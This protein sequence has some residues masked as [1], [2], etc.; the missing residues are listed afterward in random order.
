MKTATNQVEE[1]DLAYIHDHADAELNKISGESILITGGAGFLGYYFTKSILNWND[2]HLSKPIQISILDNL[3][4]GIPS[5]L[6]EITRRSDVTLIKQNLI[7]NFHITKHYSYIIHAASI[8]SPVYYR[9]YPIETMDVNTVGLRKILDFTRK[10]KT[11]GVLF[12]SSSEIYGDP[13]Q[14]KI[15]TP[16]SYLGNVSCIG[17]RA[18]YD[19][20]KRFGETLCYVFSKKYDLPVKIVRPFN[21]YGP[22]MKIIDGRVIADFSQCILENRDIKIYSDGSPTRTYCYIAD[23]IVGYL[24]VLV[25]G[26]TTDPYNIGIEKPEISVI[27]LAE[28]ISKIGK[29]YFQYTGKVRFKKSADQ[30]YLIDNPSRRCPDISKAQKE[31]NFYPTI[32]PDEG[33]YKTLRWYKQ[34]YY[35]HQ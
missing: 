13:T 3:M 22:G 33:L 15:P 25:F 27:E 4:L 6:K 35:P 30:N 23:A 26:K 34:I 31:L 21:N 9:K 2:Q 24:K 14:E 12:F 8:A 7:N 29:Q 11:N 10:Q 16:E 1:T 17:P 28:T 5:W 19:E 32:T 20:S 18:C